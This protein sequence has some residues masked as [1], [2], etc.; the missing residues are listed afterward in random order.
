[1]STHSWIDI[2]IA[3]VLF[4]LNTIAFLTYGYDKWRAIRDAN[5]S[6]SERINEKTLHKYMLFAPLGSALGMLIWRH[7]TSKWSFKWRAILFFILGAL[8]Y[9]AL[10]AALTY[11]T[12]HFL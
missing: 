9:I 12:N 5:K 1:M 6:H 3:S 7:K 10:F 11:A 4:A 2:A 8:L